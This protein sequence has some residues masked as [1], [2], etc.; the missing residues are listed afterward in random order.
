MN[1]I[2][3]FNNKEF[4]EIR[5]IQIDNSPYFNL[6]DICRILDI[7]NP[8]DAKTRLNEKG[9]ATADTLT[10]GGMQTMSYINESNLYKLIFQSRKAEAEKF[11]EWVT[12]EVLPN[13]R[14]HGMYAKDELLDNPD[15]LIKI[16]TKLKEER[17]RNKQL[18]EKV[19]A[20]RPKVLFAESVESSNN[21]CL[22]GELAKIL[23]Q[24]NINI[25][26]NKLFEWLREKGYLIKQK[27]ENFNLPTQYSM[28]LGLMTVKKSIVNNPDGTIRTT[29][30]P[31]ITGKGQIYFVNKFL[32]NIA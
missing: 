1:D 25:G 18:E 5:A 8:R 22:V 26:Q 17:A 19:Q 15:F 13:I 31:K 12:S 28:E 20:D 16:A 7:S 24:N 29:R 10:N 30:T 9:V 2:Q 6:K 11:T 3:V 32:K 27:G 23:K 4:G 21:S 14:K